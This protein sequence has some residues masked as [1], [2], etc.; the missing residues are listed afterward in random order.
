MC[1]RYSLTTPVESVARLFGVD[2]RPNLAPRWNIAPTQEVL[3]VRLAADGTRRFASLVWGLVPAWSNDPGTSGRLIHARADTVAVK[4]SF[5]AAFRQRRCLMVADAFY[6]WQERPDGNLPWRITLAPG[7][8]GVAPPFAFAGLWERRA[9]RDGLPALETCALVTTGAN[10]QLA[11]I[12]HRMPVI[13]PPDSHAAWLDPATP[14]PALLSM[15]RPY[16][17]AMAA[18]RI[19]TRIN[20]PRNEGPEVLAPPAPDETD[21]PAGPQLRL[22]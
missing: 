5:R 22:L 9:A 13:L 11:P 18:A 16:A 14:L 8:D 3:A 21:R 19:S 15:L 7:P 6:E 17:G 4:P 12:H 2:E 10:A 20:S 1:G